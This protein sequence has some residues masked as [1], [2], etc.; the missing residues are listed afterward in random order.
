MRRGDLGQRGR[1]KGRDRGSGRAA[2]T[3]R[4]GRAG[5]PEAWSGWWRSGQAGAG[6]TALLAGRPRGGAGG[7]HEEVAYPGWGRTAFESLS[8]SRAPISAGEPLGGPISGRSAWERAPLASARRVLPLV[9]RERVQSRR[10]ASQVPP[11]KPSDSPFLIVSAHLS[12][13]S[14]PSPPRR[15]LPLPPA[16]CCPPCSSPP[17]PASA[18]APSPTRTS[19]SMLSPSASSRSSHGA[20]T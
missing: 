18:S 15:P 16:A 1:G 11:S 17:A 12:S 14:S 6:D 2:G 20:S 4:W 7:C 5:A 19:Y 10:A 3:G 13:S 8:I 9:R